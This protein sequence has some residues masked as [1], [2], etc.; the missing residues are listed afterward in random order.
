MIG[1][2]ASTRSIGIFSRSATV[3]ARSVMGLEPGPMNRCTLS[4][5]LSFSYSSTDFSGLDSSS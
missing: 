3:E 5:A 2:L 1:L 4:T